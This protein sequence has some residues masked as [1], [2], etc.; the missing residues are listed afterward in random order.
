MKLKHG[1]WCV[2]KG[3]EFALYVC[4]HNLEEIDIEAERTKNMN[5]CF[6]TSTISTS[7]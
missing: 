3:K 4:F 1:I 7:L 6:I 5:H 2:Y